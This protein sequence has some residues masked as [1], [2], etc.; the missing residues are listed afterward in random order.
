MGI[1]LHVAKKY[2][3]QYGTTAGFKNKIYDFRYLMEV[4]DIEPCGEIEEGNIFEI[5]KDDWKAGIDHPPPVDV[6]E[7]DSIS[8]AL[9]YLEMTKEELI[10]LME[11]FLKESDPDNDYLA[12]NFF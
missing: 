4:L 8:M 12:L 9:H 10:S 7:A 3:V 5:Y 2:D 11:S 6:S 1:N